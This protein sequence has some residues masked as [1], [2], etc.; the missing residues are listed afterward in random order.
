MSVHKKLDKVRKPRVHITYE[1]ETGEN[2]EK[3]ELPF[4]VGVMGDYSGNNPSVEK[5]TLKNRNFIEIE[6][7]NFD[8]VMKKIGPGV[9]V[10]VDNTL[11]NDGSELAVEL[12][13]NK[14]EDFDPANIAKQVE[15]LR[16]LLEA[17]EKLSELLTKADRSE[18][19]EELLEKVL[20]NKDDLAALSQELGTKASDKE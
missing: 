8:D 12:Q 1:V 19:L 17:R 11:K 18:E 4:V 7:D 6:S 10:K 5:K 3:K 13:F 2:Q 16:K 15:P 20:Q 14:M 9:R